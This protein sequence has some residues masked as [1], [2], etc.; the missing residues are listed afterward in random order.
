MALFA[1]PAFVRRARRD[2]AT[3]DP[4]MAAIIAAV[5]PFKPGVVPNT[6]DALVRSIIHQ[7]LSMKAARTIV[8]RVR[9]LCSGSRLSPAA[10]SGQHDGALR[11]AGL[12]RQKIRYVRSVCEH[13]ASGAVDPRRL[14]RLPDE[15]VIA[16]L[17]DIHG[18][19]VWTAEMI[20]MFNLQR[21]DV[22][23]VDD[24]GLRRALRR[25]YR[26]PATASR[27]RLVRAGERFRP[28]RSVATWY[29]WSGLNTGVVPGF[30]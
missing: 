7:Q 20:L 22:W 17:V 6:F 9:Q 10:L 16:A 29:L 28:Y 3:A 18:I 30:Q 5:G 13:F 14:R 19:G 4:T 24:L 12:S 15:Q 8:G 2:L 21:P 1:D 25:W 11:A 23:P 27:D 26:L